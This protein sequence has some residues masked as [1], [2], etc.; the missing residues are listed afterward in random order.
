[1]KLT[2]LLFA[3]GL[4]VAACTL[5]PLPS[6][7]LLEEATVPT[8]APPAEASPT[9]QGDEAG[10]GVLLVVGDWGAGNDEQEEVAE[11]MRIVAEATD[12]A[13]ILTTGDNFYS[14]DA[15]ELMAPFAWAV[16][17][18]EFWI[19]WGNHDVEDSERI[20]V[21]EETFGNPPRWTVRRWGDYDVVILDS[22]QVTSPDQL[23]FLEKV[24]AESDRP[25]IVAFHHPVL[26]CGKYGNSE[27]ALENWVPL[28]DDVVLVLAGHDHNYQRFSREGIVYVVSGGGGRGL[29][30]LEDCPERQVGAEVNHFLIVEQ[31]QNGL[32]VTA[33][34]P[35]GEVIDRFTVGRQ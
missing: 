3:T 21:V 34:D 5:Q 18:V 25:A 11:A 8:T 17:E 30:D 6:T 15:D 12:V 7:T 10:P 4:A 33:V 14:D 20:A 1:M 35:R 28:F 19:S 32:T 16:G 2:F 31:D 26:S 23:A 9:T 27:K 22:N 29:Y 24:M 13:A